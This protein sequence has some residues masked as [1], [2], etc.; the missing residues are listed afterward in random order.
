MIG[1]VTLAKSPALLLIIAIVAAP[2]V[3]DACLLSCETP[4]RASISSGGARACHHSPPA[5]GV[6]VR[7]SAAG[8]GHHHTAANGIIAAREQALRDLRHSSSDSVSAIQDS[9]DRP[10]ARICRLSPLRPMDR[11]SHSPADTP[12]RI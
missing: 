6:Q 9:V 1:E 8:C 3:L 12:L 2:V 11:P 5:A 7:T 10:S 4:L